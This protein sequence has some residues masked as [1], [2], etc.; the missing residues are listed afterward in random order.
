M[1]TGA[2]G[3]TGAVAVRGYG[4][5]YVNVTFRVRPH[6]LAQLKELYPEMRVSEMVRFSMAYTLDKKPACRL[7]VEVTLK[8]EVIK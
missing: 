2:T 3:A 5:G 6:L 8:G 7:P 4:D 1:V